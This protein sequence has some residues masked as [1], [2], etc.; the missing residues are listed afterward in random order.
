MSV[1]SCR[2][3]EVVCDRN[4]SVIYSMG[5]DLRW[6]PYITRFLGLPEDTRG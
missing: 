6:R 1:V 2:D 4:S 3:S 5:L